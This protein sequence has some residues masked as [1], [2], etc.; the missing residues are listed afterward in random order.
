MPGAEL[1]S[2]P[3]V[4]PFPSVGEAGWVRSLPL[5]GGVQLHA[6]SGDG[7]ALRV[8]DRDRDGGSTAHRD[9]VG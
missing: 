1:S 6:H 5:A 7:I 9:A 2:L 4:R 3:V 8:A